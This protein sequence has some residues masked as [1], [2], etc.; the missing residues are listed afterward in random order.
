MSAETIHYNNK[1]YD[2]I[3]NKSYPFAY[4]KN[5]ELFIGDIHDP[6]G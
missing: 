3:K 5:N 1:T 2:F 4:N 6:H